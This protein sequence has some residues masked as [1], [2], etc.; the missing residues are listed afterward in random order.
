MFEKAKPVPQAK[1]AA[2][3]GS[4]TG[5]FSGDTAFGDDLPT[6]GI[7]ARPHENGDGGDTLRVVGWSELTARLNAARD[8]RLV[9]RRDAHGNAV[10]GPGSD[11]S[12]F[13]DAAARYFRTR[14]C[15]EPDVNPVALEHLKGSPGMI[16]EHD[17]IKNQNDSHNEGGLPS[18]EVQH[19]G[20]A[21][22]G[23]ARED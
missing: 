19:R 8:L 11:H 12:N 9:L 20:H 10:N 7:N 13:A 6:G 3:P 23:D 4:L 21:V 18:N 17:E 22:P 2:N 5:R 1:A 15:E 16:H 14:H